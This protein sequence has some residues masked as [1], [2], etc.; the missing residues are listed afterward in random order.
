[1]HYVL[2]RCQCHSSGYSHTAHSLHCRHLVRALI[3]LDCVYTKIELHG[4]VSSGDT[5]TEMTSPNMP[6]LVGGAERYERLWVCV[7]AAAQGACETNQSSA[8]TCG[9][10]TSYT[11]VC[12]SMCVL[13]P[14]LGLTQ[15]MSEMIQGGAEGGLARPPGLSLSTQP[16]LG[17]PLLPICHPGPVKPPERLGQSR[18]TGGVAGIRGSV[19]L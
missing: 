9:S 3:K 11:W 5:G 13:S 19:K 16:T 1:M 2:L 18:G 10:C 14:A 4:W 8:Y 15:A 7:C 12:D 17:W 6:W